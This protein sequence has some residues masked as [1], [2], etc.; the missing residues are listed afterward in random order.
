MKTANQWEKET[1]ARRRREFDRARDPEDFTEPLG[2]R[3]FGVSVDVRL[4]QAMLHL[5]R[6]ECTD[7]A[8]AIAY[9]L[10]RFPFVLTICTVAGGQP[11]TTYRQ[12]PDGQWYA[13]MPPRGRSE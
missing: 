10:Q 2:C 4:K 3:L 13:Y 9:V 8:G 7:M 1:I 6:R 11:D 12:E 5:P